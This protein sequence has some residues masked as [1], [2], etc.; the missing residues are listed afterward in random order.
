MTLAFMPRALVSIYSSTGVPSGIFPNSIFSTLAF[1]SAAAA[2]TR[3][4]K[5]TSTHRRPAYLLM[6]EF[7]QDASC[8]RIV[9]GSYS[10]ARA[11]PERHGSKKGQAPLP[12]GPGGSSAQNC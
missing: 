12:Q 6:G 5:E 1:G 11:L 4:Q 3:A 9:K 8:R 2:A 7:S 10:A